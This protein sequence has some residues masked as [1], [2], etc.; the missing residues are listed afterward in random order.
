MYNYLLPAKSG[1]LSYLYLLNR[2][3]RISVSES[4]SG[5]LAARFL[6]FLAIALFL[7]IVLLTLRQQLPPWTIWLLATF[8]LIMFAATGASVWLFRI[9]GEPSSIDS[10]TR[11]TWLARQWRE[12]SVGMRRILRQGRYRSMLLL[13]LLIWLSV[14]TYTFLIVLGMGYQVDFIQLVV[15]SI[16][17]VPLTLLPVQGF[18]NL[19]THEFGWVIAFSFF[20]FPRDQA[21]TI[22]VGVHIILLT[23]VLALGVASVVVWHLSTC[24]SKQVGAHCAG[25]DEI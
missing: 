24:T 1:E 25:A 16:V 5:L 22:A 11:Q 21:L 8:A 10:N 20:G 7:P 3:L 18:G 9:R 23:F 12:F 17:M 14:Y 15:V 13:S 6:D 4:A 19:G 2:R